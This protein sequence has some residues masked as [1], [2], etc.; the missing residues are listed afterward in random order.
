MD[1]LRAD[2]KAVAVM[3]TVVREARR[4]RNGKFEDGKEKEERLTVVMVEGSRGK[5]VSSALLSKEQLPS[6]RSITIGWQVVLRL[7]LFNTISKRY[8]L[9]CSCRVYWAEVINGN[10][11]GRWVCGSRE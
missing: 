1:G 10:Q 7:L 2:C 6:L 4:S 5:D 3:M 11:P 8:L 9:A